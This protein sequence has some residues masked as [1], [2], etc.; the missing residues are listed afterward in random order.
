MVSSVMGRRPLSL[1]GLEKG[2]LW[3]V[4]KLFCKMLVLLGGKKKQQKNPKELVRYV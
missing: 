3:L 1:R 2:S 4:S